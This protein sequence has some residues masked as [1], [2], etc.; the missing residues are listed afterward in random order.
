MWSSLF[1]VKALLELCVLFFFNEEFSMCTKIGRII[2]WIF[3][4]PSFSL[5]NYE[6]MN[7]SPFTCLS[8]PLFFLLTLF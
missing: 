3:M 7:N 5:H 8:I 2:W 4:F 6:P 1:S